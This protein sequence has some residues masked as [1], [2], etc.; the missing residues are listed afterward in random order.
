MDYDEKTGMYKRTLR[1]GIIIGALGVVSI[2]FASSSLDILGFASLNN[3]QALTS[4]IAATYQIATVGFLP[5][6][7]GLVSA[8][9]VMRFLTNHNPAAV[10]SSEDK[11]VD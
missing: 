10:V 6:S 2:I 9:L 3:N 5:F 1:A 11:L 8:A 4:F 7:A